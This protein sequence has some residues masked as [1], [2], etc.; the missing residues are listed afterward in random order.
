[1][2]KIAALLLL[3]IFVCSAFATVTLPKIFGDNMVLQRNKPISIWGWANAGEKIMVQFNQQQKSVVTDKMGKWQ[4]LLQPENAGGPYQLTVTGKNKISLQNILVGEVWICSGQSNMEMPIAGWGKINNYE[5]EI[6]NA[7][8]AF[9]R[10]FK[11]PNTVSATLKEDI[12]GGEWK[13]CSP[14]TAG[15]FSATAYFFARELYKQLKVPIG[16]INSSWG[17]TQSEAWTSKEGFAQSTEFKDISAALE[18]GDMGTL[19]KQKSEAV[20]ANI[21]KAQGG[22]ENT[23]GTADWKNSNFDD[24]KWWPMKLPGAWEENGFPGLDGVA[25]FRKTI[26]ISEADAGKAAV[27]ELA[28]VDDIDETYVNGVKV[29]SIDKWDELRKYNIAAGILKAGKNVIAVKVTDQQGGGGIYGDAATMKLTIDKTVLPLAGE[30][31]F[32]VESVASTGTGGSVGPNDFPCILFNAMINPLLPYTIKGAIWYQGETNAGRAY[33]YR[34]AFPLM[35][36]DWRQHFKQ[37]DFPFLFVQLST[38]GT[39][40]ANSNN[41]SNWAELREAQAMTLSLPNTG[42]AVTTD[43]GNPLDIHPKNKQDVGKRLAAI[44]LHDVYAQAGEYTG[45]VYQS[46]KTNGSQVELSFT[47][48]GGGWLVKDKYGYI[49]GFEI[50]GADKKFYFAKAMIKNDKVIVFSDNVLQ[51]VAVRYNWCDDASE[52][53]LFNTNSFPAAPFRTD[54]WDGVTIKNKYSLNQ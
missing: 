32:R 45:P 18:K 48:T 2:K 52:G 27:L 40:A 11:V 51:P 33:Q 25:W 20:M 49:K 13:V 34:T 31:L 7:D 21:K 54:N 38:F 1:M 19:I 44:A 30:W 43:I 12:T 42:M 5:S 4:L 41:G 9:I 17:G 8:Y 22:L 53:N 35:I 39:A 50:A 46:M 23:A 28:K 16:L 10:H 29:G 36:N 6:A 37:G 24:S 15:D 14:A 3:S 47:H 26:D